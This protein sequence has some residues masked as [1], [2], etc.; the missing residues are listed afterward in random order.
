MISSTSSSSAPDPGVV[1]DAVPVR[2]AFACVEAAFDGESMASSGRGE[3]PDDGLT[4]SWQKAKKLHE[5]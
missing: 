5:E 2:F 4:C 1:T 3:W